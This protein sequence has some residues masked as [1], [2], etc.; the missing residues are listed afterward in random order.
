MTDAE[1]QRSLSTLFGRDTRSLSEVLGYTIIF[2]I[3]LTS[4]TLLVVG[5][6]S[7]LEQSRESEQ[8]ANAERAFDVVA[9]NM[10]QIYE[11]N[12]PSRATEIDLGTSEIFYASNV[13]MTVY[14]ESE[15]D[16]ITEIDEFEY[17]LRPIEMRVTD[18][19]SLV[20]EAGAVFR[21]RDDG[22]AMVR[23]P[24]L[25]L[26]SDR[27]TVPIVQTTAPGVESAG[28]TTI[29]LRGQS[30]DRTVLEDNSADSYTTVTIELAG[31]DR[32]EAWE[33]YFTDISAIESCTTDD[34]RR[35]VR[36]EVSGEPENLSV[37]R[38]QIELSLII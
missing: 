20:Y 17:E 34:A 31:S 18:D 9:D 30:V 4:V 3:V 1:S 33:R 32:Y 14:V 23:D 2:A 5:G 11:R 13:S 16:G 25:T 22:A 37:T 21:D 38:Q 24:P 8:V 36:C 35:L 27:V 12:A 29:L 6:M 28:G 7:S 15:T 10:A 19:E 26:K